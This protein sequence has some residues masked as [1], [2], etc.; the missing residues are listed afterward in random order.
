[1]PG[2][3]LLNIDQ[4]AP[5]RNLNLPAVSPSFNKIKST[6]FNDDESD[7]GNYESEHQATE[8][9]NG[10][11]HMPKKQLTPRESKVISESHEVEKRDQVEAMVRQP[12]N[13]AVR[14][15]RTSR[16]GLRVK[17]NKSLTRGLTACESKILED[18]FEAFDYFYKFIV[19]GDEQV[20]KSNF[21]LRVS[22]GQ[23]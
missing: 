6:F 12:S 20:G 2:S 5:S 9:V 23:F 13:P 8:G 15:L 18:P 22:K 21:L 11:E 7:T 3:V 16:G 14:A 19:I 17:S 1:M 4:G 10:A